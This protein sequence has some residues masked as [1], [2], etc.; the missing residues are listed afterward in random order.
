MFSPIAPSTVATAVK[1]PSTITRSTMERNSFQNI[2]LY[3]KKFSSNPKDFYVSVAEALD[4][5]VDAHVV[6]RRQRYPRSERTC[7]ENLWRNCPPMVRYLAYSPQRTSEIATKACMKH[8]ELRDCPFVSTF[9]LSS[10]LQRW[11]VPV[12][13]GFLKFLEFNSVLDFHLGYIHF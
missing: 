9:F 13:Q 11:K 1:V 10:M 4:A 3:I 7:P 12:P 2:H 8:P 6:P 5:I